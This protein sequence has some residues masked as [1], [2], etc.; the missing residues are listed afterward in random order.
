MS[1]NK[2]LV[3]PRVQLDDEELEAAGGGTHPTIVTIGPVI[4][5][6]LEHCGKDTILGPGTCNVGTRGCC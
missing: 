5:A 2:K 3:V 1:V 4:T 6:S